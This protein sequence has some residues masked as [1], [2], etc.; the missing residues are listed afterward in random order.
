MIRMKSHDRKSEIISEYL[1]G[2][3]SYESLARKHEVKARTIQSWVRAY[4]AAHPEL[5]AAG[6]VDEAAEVKLLKKRLEELELKNELLDEML[7]LSEKA[8]GI[9][10]R[11][12]YGTRQ[13]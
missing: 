4:R 12:K 13:S 1:S 11:K 6:R 9:D 5:K 2:E 8:T 7:R 10:L 3:E